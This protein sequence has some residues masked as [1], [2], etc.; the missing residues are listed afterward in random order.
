MLKNPSAWTGS[1]TVN[2]TILRSRSSKR[3]NLVQ[4]VQN[5]RNRLKKTAS[6]GG[7]VHT[8]NDLLNKRGI[9][10]GRFNTSIYGQA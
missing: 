2:G 1:R 7:T 6:A 8:R 10:S 4:S 3:E 9:P 5:A